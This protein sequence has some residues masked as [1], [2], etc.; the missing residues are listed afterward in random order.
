MIIF[1]KVIV[2]HSQDIDIDKIHHLV[3]SP[4][5]Y[6]YSFVC[7]CLVLYSLTTVHVHVQICVSITTVK[8]Q[9]ALSSLKSPMLSFYNHIHH[10]LFLHSYAAP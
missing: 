1:C 7:V 4:W 8:I 2:Y 10:H 3:Q 5:L 6:L 9:N